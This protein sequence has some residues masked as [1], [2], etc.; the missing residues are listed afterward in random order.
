MSIAKQI[1]DFPDY[2]VSSAGN[3]W[4]EHR[5]GFYL[6]LKPNKQGSVAI[7]ANGERNLMYIHRLVAQSFVPIPEQYQGLSVDELDVHHINFN[8]FDNRA[9]NLQWLTKTEHKQLHSESEVTKQRLSAVNKGKHR[10]EETRKKISVAFK[11]KPNLALSKAVAQYTKTGEFIAEYAS[12]YEAE[13]QTKVNQGNICNC[14]NGKY[15][16]AGG[17]IWRYN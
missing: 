11:G 17:Y 14:C 12:A 7:Y 13:R 1:Q 5:N 6:R 2:Y 4:R 10:T 3:I 15:K 16:S 8:H 9:S